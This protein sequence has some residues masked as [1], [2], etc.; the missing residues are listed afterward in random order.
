MTQLDRALFLYGKLIDS[1]GVEPNHHLVL[2]GDPSVESARIY[3]FPALSGVF[4]YD[5]A[6]EIKSDQVDYIEELLMEH[7]SPYTLVQPLC[8][9]LRDVAPV[10]NSVGFS[11]FVGSWGMGPEEIGWWIRHLNNRPSFEKYLATTGVN[12]SA[13]E[14]MTPACTEQLNR[15]ELGV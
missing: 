14:Q 11:V 5:E 3:S 1:L 12:E 8:T 6:T 15:A 4:S 7:D 10:F 13:V 9:K 2:L